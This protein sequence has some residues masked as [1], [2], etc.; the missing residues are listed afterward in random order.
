MR[1]LRLNDSGGCSI[2][3]FQRD[4]IPQYAI[5][6]HTWGEEDDE[7]TFKDLMDNTGQTK[8]GFQNLQFC[9][10]QAKTDGLQY[11]W[12]DTCCIDKSNSTEL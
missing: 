3:R 5:L 6:S 1:L 9:G 11:F 10:N 2:V 7:F 8:K 4:R 12:V